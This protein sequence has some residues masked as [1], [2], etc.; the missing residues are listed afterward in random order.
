MHIYEDISQKTK[1][2]SEDGHRH[3]KSSSAQQIAPWYAQRTRKNGA[4]NIRA[5]FVPKS[6]SRSRR[7]RQTD[8]CVSFFLAGFDLRP[9]LI[10]GMTHKS[11]AAKWRGPLFVDISARESAKRARPPREQTAHRDRTRSC[12]LFIVQFHSLQHT[13]CSL[14]CPRSAFAPAPKVCECGN[15]RPHS[16][17]KSSEQTER[18]F[19]V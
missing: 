3:E 12:W 19:Y 11:Q 17:L 10:P 8:V 7:R 4:I 16:F 18:R 13:V 9:L 2:I 1:T 6:T 15:L 5:C 14:R